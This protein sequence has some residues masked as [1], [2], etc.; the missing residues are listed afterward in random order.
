MQSRLLFRGLLVA[1]FAIVIYNQNSFAESSQ[2]IDNSSQPDRALIKF[3]GYSVSP[4]GKW[5]VVISGG[6]SI[7]FQSIDGVQHLQAVIFD[8]HPKSKETEEDAFHEYVESRRQLEHENIENKALV[9]DAIN[10]AK[11]DR[12]EI[13]SWCIFDPATGSGHLTA[14]LESKRKLLVISYDTDKGTEAEFRKSA[15]NVATSMM[16]R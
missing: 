14:I 8:L 10:Y 4:L 11:D 2:L 5:T 15:A 6:K 7:R 1:T 3:P 9:S 16:F 13:A 12:G